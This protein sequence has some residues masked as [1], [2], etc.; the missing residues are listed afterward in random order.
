M[1]GDHVK[2]NGNKQFRGDRGEAITIGNRVG[3]VV[4]K[5]AKD[6]DAYVVEFGS[7]SFVMRGCNLSRF[8]FAP[9]SEP[10]RTRRRRDDDE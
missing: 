6:D 2:Y 4:A 9:G 5:V 1:P 7:D 8:Y 10:E 3:E